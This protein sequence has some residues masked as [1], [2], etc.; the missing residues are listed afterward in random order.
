MQIRK[1]I[2]MSIDL[3]YR[4]YN[5]DIYT[6]PCTRLQRLKEDKNHSFKI[7]NKKNE[8][9]DYYLQILI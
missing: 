2:I 6:R 7:R 5:I 3:R 1:L 9:S 8:Q 4:T